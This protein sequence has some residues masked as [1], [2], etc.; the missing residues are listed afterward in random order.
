[1]TTKD[2]PPQSYSDLEGVQ[3]SPVPAWNQPQP[4][5]E[6]MILAALGGSIELHKSGDEVPRLEGY[7]P[8]SNRQGD[9]ALDDPLLARDKAARY[10][11]KDTQGELGPF[12][13]VVDPRD[14]DHAPDQWPSKKTV[15][16]HSAK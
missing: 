7:I 13:N 4:Q 15:A 2:A 12:P 10:Q 8:P 14:N 5:T 6:N 3:Y 9:D 16:Q 1:M 11:L